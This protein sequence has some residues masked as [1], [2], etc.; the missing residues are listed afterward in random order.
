[1]GKGQETIESQRKGILKAKLVF[2][3]LVILF[4]LLPTQRI[5]ADNWIYYF[6]YKAKAPLIEKDK[7]YFNF[8]EETRYK[9]GANYYRKSF[10]GISKSVSPNLDLALYYAF[11]QKRSNGWEKLSMFWP[12]VIYRIPFKTMVL[13]SNSKLE[14]HTSQNF[15]RAR[16]KLRLIHPLNDRVKVWVGDEVRYFFKEDYWG[17]NEFLIGLNIK[18]T[19]NLSLDSYY[20]YRNAK[21]NGDWDGTNCLRFAFSLKF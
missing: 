6:E 2:V 13:E 11:K 4:V 7:L 20:D 1:M 19:G 15:W 9:D 14:R 17:E 5:Y 3:L 10:F 8:K 12:E 16:E 18:F 21:T